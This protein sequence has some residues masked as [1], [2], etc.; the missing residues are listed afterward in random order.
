MSQYNTDSIAFSIVVYTLFS[1][2]Y[3]IVVI[4]I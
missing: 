1:I 4:R 3:L 2:F